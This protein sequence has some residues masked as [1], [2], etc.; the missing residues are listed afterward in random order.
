MATLPFVTV[1]LLTLTP[2]LLQSTEIVTPSLSLPPLLDTN[3]S[4]YIIAITMAL[5]LLSQPQLVSLDFFLELKTHFS[6]NGASS[7]INIGTNKTYTGYAPSYGSTSYV[8]FYFYMS[9]DSFS[10]DLGGYYNYFYIKKGSYAS[11]SIYDLSYYT[12]SSSASHYSIDACSTS[13]NSVS[14]SGWYYVSIQSYYGASYP[15]TFKVTPSQASSSTTLYT[16][17]SLTY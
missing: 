4:M 16:Y 7:G 1:L 11:S 6:D 3:T 13:A 15:F 2:L 5:P 14:G 17:T 8:R 9:S 12:Y 10:F